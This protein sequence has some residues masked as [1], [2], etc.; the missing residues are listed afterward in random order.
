MFGLDYIIFRLHNVYG[1]YQNIGDKYRNLVGIFMNQILQ[2]RPMTIFGNGEQQRAFSYI[3]DI[4]PII[5][6]SPLMT[7]ARNRIFDIGAEKPYTV[8][9]VAE[10]VAQTM[11]V[12]SNIVYLPPRKELYI[13]F[14]D[15]SASRE[16]FGDSSKTPLEEGL[17]KMAGWV[18]RVGSRK[19]KDFKNIEIT[20]NLPEAWAG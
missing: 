9:Q 10:A 5:A 17:G 13:A 15:H 12:K 6:R 8:N 1:E 14:S 19:G 20:R 4:A 11:E 16:A 2:G 7:T 18:K 3:G